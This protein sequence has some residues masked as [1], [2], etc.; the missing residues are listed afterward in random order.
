MNGEKAGVEEQQE[1]RRGWMQKRR[2]LGQD[3]VDDNGDEVPL[4]ES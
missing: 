4:K 1:C 3:S 2:I